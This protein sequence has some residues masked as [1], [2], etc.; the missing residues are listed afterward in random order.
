MINIKDNFKALLLA[1]ILGVMGVMG[2][3]GI[4]VQQDKINALEVEIDGREKE[5]ESLSQLKGYYKELITAREDLIINLNNQVKTLETENEELRTIRVK[6][7]AY[8]PLDNIDGRQAEG[9][10]SRTATGR[11]VGKNIAAADPKKLPYGTKLEIPDWGE[12]IV[13]DTGGALRRDNK[14]IRVDLF[15][16]TYNSAMQF[17]VKDLEVKILEWGGSTD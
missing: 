12:V 11:R 6:L 7:T 4:N 10:P 14:N 5:I 13:G 1:I 2:V 15:H 9:N 3:I 16:E 8:S 17:G